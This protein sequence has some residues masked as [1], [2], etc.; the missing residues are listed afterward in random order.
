[1][2][3][4]NNYNLDKGGVP[5]ITI[6]IPT[7]QPTDTHFSVEPSLTFSLETLLVRLL[8]W[9]TNFPPALPFTEA[10]VRK[11]IEAWHTLSP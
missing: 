4:T 1:M 7:K 3:L 2:S 11:I 6:T 10:I 8:T 5:Q 9:D